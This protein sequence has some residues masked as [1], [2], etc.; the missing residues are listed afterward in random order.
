[1]PALVAKAVNPVFWGGFA[2]AVVVV[3][4]IQKMFPRQR[5]PKPVYTDEV[6][7]EV[8]SA[9]SDAPA[10]SLDGLYT[11]GKVI[12]V[13]NGNTATI[14]LPLKGELLKFSCRLKGTIVP[15][16]KPARDLENR[17]A[18]VI[19]AQASQ[20]GLASMVLNKVV[21]VRCHASELAGRQI[22]EL[23]VDDKTPNQAAHT[24]ENSV[25]AKMIK[26]GFA[27]PFMQAYHKR[28]TTLTG[29]ARPATTT[30][31]EPTTSVPRS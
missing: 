13:W 7:A 5:T 24:E 6:P 31:S 16:L 10:F 3:L 23:W 17:D 14:V 4:A 29:R 28:T 12:R 22:V 20:A 25:N 30:T 27:R 19:Q 9:T 2:S 11:R 1:M 21:S 18:E 15:D 8:W 26:L